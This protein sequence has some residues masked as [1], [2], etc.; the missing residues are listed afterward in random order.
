MAREKSMTMPDPQA[1]N[2]AAWKVTTVRALYAAFR[3]GDVSGILALLASDVEW[4]EP[5]NPYNPAAGTRRGH[6]GFLEWLRIGQASED[7]VPVEPRQFMP[8]TQVWPWWA[9]RSAWLKRRVE[10]TRP[11]LCIWSRFETA[12][13]RGSKSSSIRMR[14][15]KRFVRGLAARH[16]RNRRD[17]GRG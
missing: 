10:Y 14:R 5:D 12:G 17:S 1:H 9:I 15:A 8:T 13:L 6:V 11:T 16:S 4:S 3:K 2:T 7:M